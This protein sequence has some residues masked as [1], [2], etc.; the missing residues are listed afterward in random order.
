[1]ITMDSPRRRSSRKHRA[2]DHSQPAAERAR[3]RRSARREARFRA[4]SPEVRPYA[5]QTFGDPP[6]G[7]ASVACIVVLVALVLALL[8][9]FLLVAGM[10]AAAVCVVAV[11]A[12]PDR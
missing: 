4:V 12:D 8:S 2:H 7:V 10:F 9:P 6:P 1:M 3:R 11:R 5:V